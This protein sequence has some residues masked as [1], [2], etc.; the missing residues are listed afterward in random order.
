MQNITNVDV[1]LIRQPK[2]PNWPT[3]GGGVIFNPKIY[4]ADFCH[5]RLYFGLNSKSAMYAVKLELND[6]LGK[7]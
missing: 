3:V 1:E 7:C 6:F 2:G 5:Y 4:I